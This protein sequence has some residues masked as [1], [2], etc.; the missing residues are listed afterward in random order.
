[1][2]NNDS[3]TSYEATRD[4]S[5]L[6]LFNTASST[7]Y[8]TKIVVQGDASLSA[9]TTKPVE[10]FYIIGGTINL[11]EGLVTETTSYTI[12]F[13]TIGS[14]CSND[15]IELTYYVSPQEEISFSGGSLNQS[16][17]Y[18]DP[19]DPII[20]TG[21]DRYEISWSP[22]S[23]ISISTSDAQIISTTFDISGTHLNTS[24]ATTSYTYTISILG[25][26]D[27]CTSSDLVT[28]T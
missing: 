24:G 15:S 9:T 18:G 28:G 4:G 26:G 25:S 5:V 20:L 7:V 23:P 16:L 14:K 8:T 21:A 10:G 11:N 2:I 12:D 19:M 27:R 17:C 6:T 13:N 3:N 22:S 1:M